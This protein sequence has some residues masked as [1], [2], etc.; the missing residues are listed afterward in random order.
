VSAPTGII[1]VA[2][3]VIEND[4]QQVLLTKRPE[5]VHQGGLW[6]FPGG[7]LE[8]GE[9]ASEALV[10]ELDEELGIIVSHARPLIQIPHDY[11]DRRVLLDVYLIEE[12]S[13]LPY[14]KEGQALQWVSRDALSDWSMPSANLPI[15]RA[16][17]LPDRYQITPAQS[18]TGA[19]FMDRLEA[20]LQSGIRLVQYRDADVDDP[21]YLQMARQIIELAHRYDAQVMLNR[22]LQ[23]FNQCPADGLHLSSSRLM[24]L[25]ER[26][27]SVDVLLSASCHDPVE[28]EQANR[29]GADFIVISPVQ[30]TR[31][32]PGAIPLGWKKC[33]QL[34]GLAQMPAYALGGL[35][36]ADISNAQ[37][38]G[39]Q[40]IAAIRS[41]WSCAS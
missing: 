12:Y 28:V 1:H 4:R 22:S 14:G 35:G 15:I 5:H 7:K 34:T 38:H 2:V 25:S 31:S 33:Q 29:I 24:A 10:R 19:A 20:C 41:L 37:L 6:E 27:V 23:V 3:A 39:A 17:Q 11:S 36:K 8:T 9:K 21:Q 16:V 26:P 30:K 32:H 40:G 13:A 18:A